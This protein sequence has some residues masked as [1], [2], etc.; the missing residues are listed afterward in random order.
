MNESELWLYRAQLSWD[1]LD[2]LGF[3]RRASR[4]TVKEP[5]GVRAVPLWPFSQ[6]LHT[7]TVMSS[8]D[9]RVRPTA[10]G[11]LGAVE[12]YRSGDAYGERP[13]SRRRY[14]DD[15]AWIALAAIDHDTQE[16][17]ALANRVLHFLQRGSAQVGDGEIGVRWVEGGA[18]FH[19]C[20]TGSTGLVAA[21]LARK[22]IVDVDEARALALACARFMARLEGDDGLVRDHMRPDGG[23]DPAV[24]TYNQGLAIGLLTE[25][26][27]VDDATALAHRT[28]EAFGTERLWASPPVFNSIFIRE[29]MR[30]HAVSPHPEWLA[31]SERYLEHVWVR[32]R[33][34]ATGELSG[35]GLGTYDKGVLLDHAGLVHAMLAL[36]TALGDTSGR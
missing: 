24:Y 26:G 1:A 33:N 32:A 27:Q 30:L 28:I 16:S 9:Q 10:E 11:L 20:S 13:A 12:S 2:R 23:M 18:N 35:G 22:G 4:I 7:S 15:N 19:A 31:Y 14:Y 8:L 36:G 6:V 34:A 25:V 3:R 21:R 29:L 17:L 5:R